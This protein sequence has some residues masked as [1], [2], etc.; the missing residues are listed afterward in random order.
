MSKLPSVVRSTEEL[1]ER[2]GLSRWT[3]SRALNNHPAVKAETRERVLAAARDF[4]FE[5]N[6]MARNL[7]GGRTGLVGVCFNELESPVLVK[8]ISILHRLLR[9]SGRRGLIELTHGDPGAERDV[10]AHFGRMR[11]DGIIT[12]YSQAA[13]TEAFAAMLGG[14]DVRVV[15]VDPI[16]ESLRPAATMDRAEAMSLII[17]HLA[18]Q[19]RRR[20]ALLGIRRGRYPD[21]WRGLHAAFARHALT[22]PTEVRVWTHEDSEA[23]DYGYGRALAEEVLAD[24]FRPEAIVALNDRVAIGAMTRLQQAGWRFPEDCAI[25]GFDDI[26]VAEHCL[27]GLTTID[28][29]SELIMG[30]ALRLL[31]DTSG[32]SS[33][34]CVV[35]PRLIP[36]GST[37]APR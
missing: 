20:L 36:R 2:L 25:T 29:Q 34:F 33:Y 24:G 37:V 14:L 10:I 13:S 4:H 16:T 18:G 28:H 23:Q 6:Q 8:K 35:N 19:G 7:Q 3:V 5:P 17:D 30:E 31:D 9:D 21:R 22:E 15:H 11:V 27:P 12:V 26:D 1:A 32:S